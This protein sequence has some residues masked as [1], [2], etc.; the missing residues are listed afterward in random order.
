MMNDYLLK[1]QRRL[2][3]FNFM[4]RLNNALLC[5]AMV[6]GLFVFFGAWWLSIIISAII[7]IMVWFFSRREK[8]DLATTANYLDTHGNLSNLLSTFIAQEKAFNCHSSWRKTF[9][10]YLR[11]KNNEIKRISLPRLPYNLRYWLLPFAF[12]AVH[13]LLNTVTSPIKPAHNFTPFEITR[14]TPTENNSSANDNN[15]SANEKKI[16]PEILRDLSTATAV[17]NHE[18]NANNNGAGISD[19]LATATKN[20]LTNPDAAN[21]SGEYFLLSPTTIWQN[22]SPR[23]NL[24]VPYR[25]IVQSYLQLHSEP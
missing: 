3:R 5:G 19:G 14:L 23:E 17:N 22:L 16:S 13:L 18:V 21:F 20:V 6:N 8:I 10:D 24:A 4:A 11:E 15:N 1:V 25:A 12:Y 7:A 2:S 9:A